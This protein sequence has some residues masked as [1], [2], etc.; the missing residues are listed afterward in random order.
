MAILIMSAN[1]A[2]IIGA[3]LFQAKDAPLYPHGWTNIVLLVLVGAGAI[4]AAN[5]QYRILNQRLAIRGS[6]KRYSL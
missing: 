2:G 5:A 6:K 4:V 3:Q 1:S